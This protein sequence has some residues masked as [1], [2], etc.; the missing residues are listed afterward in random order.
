MHSKAPNAQRL[1]LELGTPI[2]MNTNT[3]Q[4]REA[5]NECQVSYKIH[6]SETV[7]SGTFYR[8][9]LAARMYRPNK[10]M[11]R[12]FKWINQ[13]LSSQRILQVYDTDPL[14]PLKP[15]PRQF[16]QDSL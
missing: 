7:L 13:Y 9:K 1:R 6:D 5:V 16:S 10:S 11:R 8:Q 12:N 3:R 14:G 2:S 15:Q 4:T